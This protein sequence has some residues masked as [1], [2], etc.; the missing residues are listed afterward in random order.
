[1][2]FKNAQSEI[3]RLKN[4]LHLAECGCAS[5]VEERDL[6]C[7]AAESYKRRLIE[8]EDQRAEMHRR[9]AQAECDRERTYKENRILTALWCGLRD[10]VKA[11]PKSDMTIGCWHELQDFIKNQ[12]HTQ[13]LRPNPSDQRAGASPAP[14]HR[15]VGQTFS[16][17]G[18]NCPHCGKDECCGGF[19][20]VNIIMEKRNREELLA[21]AD[22][23][24]ER[25]AARVRF[26]ESKLRDCLSHIDLLEG[27][28]PMDNAEDESVYKES[29]LFGERIAACLPNQEV[30][31]PA[32]LTP[33]G[34]QAHVAGSVSTVL[35]GGAK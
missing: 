16:P 18:E 4:E 13:D 1:M 11:L 32:P 17:N 10:K 24:R 30:C 34:D 20:A 33:T 15:V 12:S 23:L 2:M 26:L 8:A 7:A 25:L 29:I 14:M 31:G 19:M 22:R 28:L 21:I 35:M 9:M 27:H 6:A 3:E 5:R